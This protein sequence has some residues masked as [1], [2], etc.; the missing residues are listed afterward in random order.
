MRK[1]FF[2]LCL[3][4]SLHL[5][6]QTTAP[7]PIQEAMANYDYETALQ[8]MEQET[9]TIPLL[10]QKGRALKGLGYTD[11][12]LL[13]Y[14]EI[15]AHDSLTARPYIEAAEC[16]K[17]ISRQR[18]AVDYYQSALRL[19]PENKYVRIQYISLLLNMRRNRDALKES[20]LLAEQDSSAYVLHLRAESMSRVYDNADVMLVIEAYQDIMKR[21]P[22]DYMAPAI[23]GNIY[24]AAHQFDDAIEATEAYRSA[25]TT[26]VLVNRVNAQ[27]YCMNKDY[28]KAIDRYNNLLQD[29]DSTLLTCL[30]AGISHYAIDDFYEARTLLKRA[31]KEDGSNVNAH[32]YL[33]RACSKTPYTREGVLHLETA[34][35]LSIPSDSIISPLYTAMADCYKMANMYKEQANILLEQYERYDKNKHKLLYEVAYIYYY[36]L[37]NIPKTEQY[38]KAYL[39]TKPKDNDK[40]QEVDEDGI[41]I[42]GENNRYNAAEAWLKDIQEKKKV[43]EF[44]KGTGGTPG[45]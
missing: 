1:L 41:P 3:S 26:N 29:G 12:A 30:Y 15:I 31:V 6:A 40:R 27:A 23:L 14:Q 21:Y 10:Y 22:K 19:N 42:I 45:N 20:S 16:C 35:N 18:E 36:S 24:I 11:K 8:L 13:V 25:D 37:K 38:L 39:R 34:L 17:A 9:P 44:F 2:L 28:L 32:Y 5:M 7:N 4:A 33:G 43:D